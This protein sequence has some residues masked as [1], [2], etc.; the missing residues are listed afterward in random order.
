MGKAAGEC[1]CTQHTSVSV[2]HA[3]TVAG[4]CQLHVPSAYLLEDVSNL[5]QLLVTEALELWYTAAR[6]TFPL[7]TPP[8]T[9]IIMVIC[10]L[11]RDA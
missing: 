4:E 3:A 11:S 8:D 10:D 7:L 9:F 6:N 1:D 5:E 2:S